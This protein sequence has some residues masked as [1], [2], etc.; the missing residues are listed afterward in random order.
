M[1]KALKI[2]GAVGLV[3]VVIIGIAAAILIPRS[4]RLNKEATAF[5]SDTF[6]L[7]VRDWDSQMLVDRATDELANAGPR[8]QLDNLYDFLRPIGELQSTDPP[9][10]S[11]F[12]RVSVAA[13]RATVANCSF[14]A[15]FS[16]DTADVYLQLRQ[17]ADTWKINAFRINSKFFVS[18]DR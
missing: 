16:K 17:E 9:Q 2:I 13:S 14:K 11:I 6:P 10:C 8:D 1:G 15:T 5:A 7:L 12:S 4:I 3:I 18:T